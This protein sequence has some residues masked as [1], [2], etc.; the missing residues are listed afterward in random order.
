MEEKNFNEEIAL[1][2]ELL[3]KIFATAYLDLINSEEKARQLAENWFLNDTYQDVFSLY[4]ICTLYDFNFK[5]VRENIKNLVLL[6]LPDRKR[7]VKCLLGVIRN[8]ERKKAKIEKA[9]VFYLSDEER[10]PLLQ[11]LYAA[12][13]NLKNCAHELGV[14]DTT[15]LAWMK[16]YDIPRNPPNKAAI[17]SKWAL[18]NYCLY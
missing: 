11:N 12:K 1:A 18:R 15:V 8:G 14:A 2:R 13:G 3:M 17:E 7:E 5:K 4:T 9:P 6:D 16:K 10:K